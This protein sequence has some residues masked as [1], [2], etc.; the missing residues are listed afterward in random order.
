MRDDDLHRQRSQQRTVGLAVEGLKKGG[1]FALRK[2]DFFAFRKADWFA[3]TKA[4]WF[5]FRKTDFSP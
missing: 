4:G 3:L 1:L 5:V 2:A